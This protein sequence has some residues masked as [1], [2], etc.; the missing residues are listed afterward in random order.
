MLTYN[1]QLQ[2]NSAKQSVRWLEWDE[3]VRGLQADAGQ[4]KS[5]ADKLLTLSTKTSSGALLWLTLED[6]TQYA[7]LDLSSA[8]QTEH[9]KEAW[10][11]KCYVDDQVKTP[12]L[13]ARIDHHGKL[14]WVKKSSEPSWASLVQ[15]LGPSLQ[16]LDQRPARIQ[17]SSLAQLPSTDIPSLVAPQPVGPLDITNAQHTVKQKDGVVWVNLDTFKQ[18][19]S[20]WAQLPNFNQRLKALQH[21]MTACDDQYKMWLSFDQDYSH[22]A[23]LVLKYDDAFDSNTFHENTRSPNITGLKKKHWG[24]HLGECSKVKDIPPYFNWEI[25]VDGRCSEL[26]YISA[27]PH[28]R[29]NQVMDVFKHLQECLKTK[30]VY[31][32]DDARNAQDHRLR[33]LR[34]LTHDDGKTWYQSHGFELLS[35]KNLFNEKGDFR[36]QQSPKSHKLSV[37]IMRN[38]QLATLATLLKPSEEQQLK[39]YSK[40]YVPGITY[41]ALTVSQLCT[42]MFKTSVSQSRQSRAASLDLNFLYQKFL[43]PETLSNKSK[44]KAQSDF[45]DA[46]QEVFDSRVFVLK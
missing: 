26:Y 33:L 27:G 13:S 1:Q 25:S 45:T 36:Y 44:N 34:P 9:S 21:D 18:M 6:A 35:C 14:T 31:L 8:N 17:R 38:T 7:L 39:L 5:L 28:A 43:N 22:A 37:E 3:F 29:G 40:K 24:L 11:L 23:Q 32:Q 20:A 12:K 2:Q 15:A 46:V 16:P 10:I 19:T 42:E 4:N 41:Q 30:A